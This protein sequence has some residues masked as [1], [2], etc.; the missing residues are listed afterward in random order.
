[1]KNNPRLHDIIYKEQFKL[2]LPI[3]YILLSIP[4]LL[5]LAAAYYE[6]DSYMGETSGNSAKAIAFFVTAILLGLAYYENIPFEF[7]S[8]TI[9]DKYDFKI[10]DTVAKILEMVKIRAAERMGLRRFDGG[11]SEEGWG[12]R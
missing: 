12:E 10:L 8:K 7:F 6:I 11:Q 2:K 9:A 1:M 5:M 3:R 4:Y